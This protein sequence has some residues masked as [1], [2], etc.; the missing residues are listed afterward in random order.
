M[1]ADLF[2][3]R[4]DIGKV[5]QLDPKS[6]LRFKL[7]DDSNEKSRIAS[8]CG[9]HPANGQFM[10]RLKKTIPLD[11]VDRFIND[12]LYKSN[13][14]ILEETISFQDLTKDSKLKIFPEGDCN[15]YVV[16]FTDLAK[17]KFGKKILPVLTSDPYL[18]GEFEFSIETNADY[19]QTEKYLD[20]DKSPIYPFFED[21]K[22]E[23]KS[24]FSKNQGEAI[25]RAIGKLISK[26]CSKYEQLLSRSGL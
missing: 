21:Y 19:L 11:R 18:S 15:W 4:L 25:L 17:S 23:V 24:S 6:Y 5:H 14:N 9:Y 13:F 2:R 8:F 3:L 7:L 1:N 12:I 26:D 10:V 16:P 22:I 20:Q